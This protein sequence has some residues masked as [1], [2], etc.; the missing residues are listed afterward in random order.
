M[1]D[2][3]KLISIG[4]V[5]SVL[6]CM[7]A[8]GQS[9]SDA[10][11]YNQMATLKGHVRVLNNPAIGNAPAAGQFIVFQ[12]ADC[13]KCLVGVYADEMGNYQVRIGQGKY[14]VI[15]FNPSSIVFDMLAPSQSRYVVA[16]SPIKDTV[17]D[18]SLVVP[19]G[20]K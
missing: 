17:F 15:V 6:L 3:M 8:F 20:T 13:R 4:L 7:G 1:K 18:I 9:R 14:K 11:V 5:T 2:V 10:D 12:R 16:D 19:T